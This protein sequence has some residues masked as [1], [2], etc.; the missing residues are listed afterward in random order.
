MQNSLTLWHPASF[1][2]F[3]Q[4][5]H[6]NARGFADEYLRFCS[7]SDLAKLSKHAVSLVDCTRKN[8]FFLGGAG[9]L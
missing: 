9:W 5:K 6:L 7:S 8:F 1:R 3:P 2:D 4:K